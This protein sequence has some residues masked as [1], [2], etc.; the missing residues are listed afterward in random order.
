MQDN[1]DG[2]TEMVSEDEFEAEGASKA[3][4]ETEEVSDTELPPSIT[5]ALETEAVSE[6]ELPPL[7]KRKKKARSH[8]SH[9]SGM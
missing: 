3:P 1:L 2:D 9:E 5:E 7:R 4:L 6:D 8:G